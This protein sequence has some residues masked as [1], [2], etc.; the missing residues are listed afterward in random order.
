MQATRILPDLQASILCEEVR[1]EANGNLFLIGVMSTIRVPQVPVTAFKLFVYDQWTAGIGVFNE[2]IRLM[3]PD[4]VTVLRES[5]SRFELKD[6]KS[7]LVNVT[8]FRQVEFKTAGIYHIEVV[9]DDVMKLRYPVV[10]AVTQPP[11]G[12]EQAEKTES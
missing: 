11:P 6:A 12:Q 8:V 5:K 7:S 3:A 10:V 4:Q 2:N 9:I 1:Q